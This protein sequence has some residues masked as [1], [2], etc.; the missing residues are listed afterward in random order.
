MSQ[1]GTVVYQVPTRF[2]DA[3]SI[4]KVL[5]LLQDVGRSLSSI[6]PSLKD[7]ELTEVLRIIEN[8][9]HTNE[10]TSTYLDLSSVRNYVEA[11]RERSEGGCLSCVHRE[12]ALFLRRKAASHCS[13]ESQQ[14]EGRR[15]SERPDDD[16]REYY[17]EFWQPEY[18]RTL[19][20][21]IGM[22][23]QKRTEERTFK[24]LIK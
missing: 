17:C 8:G 12:R 22:Q 9:S 3:R 15:F 6:D 4:H 10:G 16:L 20:T 1:E 13:M 24:T 21:V 11:Y 18:R 14:P 23:E 5:G 19:E 2:S 7:T